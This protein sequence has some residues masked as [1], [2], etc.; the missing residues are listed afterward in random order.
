MIDAKG[1]LLDRENLCFVSV[2]DGVDFSLASTLHCNT[3]IVTTSIQAIVV[4]KPSDDDLRGWY[5]LTHGPER[6]AALNVS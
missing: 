6:L 3:S 2:D 5:S 1:A 4:D